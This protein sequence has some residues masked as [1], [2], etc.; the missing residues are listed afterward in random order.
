M[1]DLRNGETK[2]DDTTT[3]EFQSVYV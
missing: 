2:Q 3:L 1:T